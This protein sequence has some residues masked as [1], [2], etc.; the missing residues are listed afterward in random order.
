MCV[1]VCGWVG[2]WVWVGVCVAKADAL[3]SL[4]KKLGKLRQACVCARAC[5]HMR[6]S[7]CG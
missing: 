4:K 5:A 7:F 2:G 3:R 6:T 1:C